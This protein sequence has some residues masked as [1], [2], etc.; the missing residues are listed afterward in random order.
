MVNVV[1]ASGQKEPFSEIKVRNSIRRAGI[2]KDL[3]EEVLTHVKT[4][5][6]ENI[7]TSEIYKHITE[8]LEASP[9]PFNKTK[10]TLKQAIMDLGPTGYPFEDYV[11]EILKSEG[12]QTHVRQILEGQCVSHEVDIIAQKDDKKILIEAKFHNSPGTR[13]DVHVS[14]YTKARFDDLKDSYN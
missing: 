13:S 8:F 4:K 5:I 6:Y 9:Q 7:H 14:L 12:Y 10:Y 2:P 1:K 3:Q 11:A